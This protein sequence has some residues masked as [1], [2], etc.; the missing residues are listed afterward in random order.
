MV[1]IQLSCSGPIALRFR[2]ISACLTLRHTGRAKIALFG[3]Q[4]ERLVPNA[5]GVVGSCR[6]ATV[7]GLRAVLGDLKRHSDL[8]GGEPSSARRFVAGAMVWSPDWV[9]TFALAVTTLVGCGNASQWEAGLLHG[10]RFKQR[11]NRTVDL[12]CDNGATVRHCFS[13]RAC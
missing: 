3:R 11:N 9:A 1:D 6:G 8:S 4:W 10:C 12:E 13:R 5:A 7:T 2:Y